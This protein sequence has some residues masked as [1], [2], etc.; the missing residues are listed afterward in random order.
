MQQKKLWLGVILCMSAFVVHADNSQAVMASLVKD[1]KPG[2]WEVQQKTAV[3]G[4]QLP[5]MN[6]MLEKVPPEMRA[7][8]EAM[9]SKKAAKL[10]S[11]KSVQVCLTKAQLEKQTTENDPRNRCQFNNI[12]REGNVTRVSMHCSKPKAQGET[13]ITRLS[14]EAWTSITQM[15]VEEQGA[16]AIN[17]E[18]KARWLS[19]DCG[20]I[21]PVEQQAPLSK[22]QK[23]QQRAAAA[24]ILEAKLKEESGQ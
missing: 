21:K 7:Q 5:D 14:A 24:K 17:N 13:T 4:Q 3:D 15:T 9:M 16:H 1:V 20:D 2:L 11:G 22:E 23:A 19:A 8:V 18:A 12:Q 6:Q 10:A